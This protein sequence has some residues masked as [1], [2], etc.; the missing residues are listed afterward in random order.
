MLATGQ[1]KQVVKGLKKERL[2]RLAEYCEFGD[3]RR[4]SGFILGD[5]LNFSLV[6]DGTVVDEQRRRHL[7]R[8]LD[9]FDDDV[10]LRRQL[11]IVLEP[12][13]STTLTLSARQQ[14]SK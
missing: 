9:C 7:L 5:D 11:N 14:V 10:L 3:M 1:S 6:A 4:G 8:F 13:H 12:A 2:A